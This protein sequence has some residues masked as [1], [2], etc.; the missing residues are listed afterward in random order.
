[1]EFLGSA[2]EA[3]CDHSHLN[4]VEK[5]ALGNYLIVGYHIGA[6]QYINGTTGAIIWQLGGKRNDFTMVDGYKLRYMHHVRIRPLSQV[7]LPSNLTNKVSNET[8]LALSLFDNAFDAIG[9]PTAPSSAAIVILLDLGA[10][11]AQ[12][13]ERYLLPQPQHA[14]AFGSV[15]FLDNGDRFVGWGTSRHITQHARDGRLVY[16]A[17]IADARATIG[18]FRAFKAPWSSKPQTRPDL[19]GY[20]WTCG[21][22]STLYASWNGATEV[23]AWVYFGAG[24]EDGLF[25][26]IALAKTDGFETMVRADTFARFTYVEARA[27]DGRVLGRSKVVKTVVPPQFWS[28]GCSEF[29]CQRTDEWVDTSDT[30]GPDGYERV[31]NWHFQETLGL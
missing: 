24:T 12:V 17:E 14:A 29:R 18:S 16:H 27:G 31:G 15:Q 5:D 6:I 9:A 30:C 8:H 1:M 13:L 23:R 20:A 28:R 2:R 11:T 7:N 25:E 19:Y 10:R 21:W 22:P 26:K 4:S 3:D